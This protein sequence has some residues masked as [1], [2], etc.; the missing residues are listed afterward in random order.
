MPRQ[1]APVQINQ[2][3]GGLNTEA[4]I[5]NFPENFSSDEQNMEICEDGSRKQ[6][7]GFNFEDS[8]I[9][10]DTTI[11][12]QNGESLGRS[13]YR[14]I[15]PGGDT[16][17][18]FLVVQIGNYMAVHDLDVSPLS[19]S[20]IYYKTF[21]DNTYSEVF[22]YAVVDGVLV[23][24][25]GK[26]AV[27]IFT[28]DADTDSITWTTDFL[29]IRD[30]FGT[31]AHPGGQNTTQHQNIQI[32]PTATGSRHIYNLR[33]QTFAL[34]RV[35]GDANTLTKV[36]P[37]H[38][39][40]LASGSEY[41]PSNADN[42]TYYLLADANLTTSRTVER[43]NAND[44]VN[45]PPGTSRAPM[46]Y[47]IIDALKR[48]SS[49][50]EQA[51]LLY[52]RNEELE[53]PI[54]N[55]LELDETPGGA[56]VL[57]QY[58]GRIWYGGF[59]SDI[60]DPHENSPRLSSYVLFSR[61]ITDITQITNCYQEA[62]PTSN[63][64][65]DLG[66]DDGG[67][68]K[69]DGA[70]GIK[71]MIPF[72]SSLFVFA[73]N[74]VWRIAGSDGDS[75]RATSPSVFKLSDYGII[76]PNSLIEREGKIF[77]WGEEG[78]FVVSQNQ[79]GDWEVGD[80]TVETI[81][82]LYEDIAIG[83]KARSVGYFDMS[84]N[85]IRW[86][87]GTGL[88]NPT[89]S[90]E[91]ILNLRFNSFTLNKIESNDLVTGVISVSGGRKISASTDPVVVDSDGEVV[92][93]DGEDV[94]SA[95]YKVN[96]DPAENLYCV[97]IEIEPTLT[98][99]FGGYKEG[100]LYDWEDLTAT[101]IDAYLISGPLTGGD[102]RIRKDIPYL[103]T[104]FKK[105]DDSGCLVNAIWD[106]ASGVTS[107]KWTNPRQAYRLRRENDGDFMVVTRNRVRGNGRSVSFKFQSEA[108]KTMRLY[109]WEFNLEA[110]DKE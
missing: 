8:Y 30:L 58:A 13:Q 17:K 67:F 82:T 12:Q 52:E 6:R 66:D 44:M 43:F 71:A 68:L 83:Q 41:Y 59:S 80:I 62:D 84:S 64:D 37:I 56:S 42:L 38:E 85:S 15:N 93:S 73:E 27:N 9:E 18:E 74:G 98:Y 55:T 99:S 7:E 78:I 110:G 4:N 29:R 90:Y 25:T 76:S 105:Q 53:Y 69:L 81:K 101:E 10:V 88:N 94:T 77:Y 24:V 54:T 22:N 31:E 79:F 2:F 11:I 35:E 36:D 104:Y 109:G 65:A 19:N 63:I 106:W 40:F 72:Q 20:R 92:T 89:D 50:Y 47:F 97:L 60:I 49:R 95:S 100:T 51:Q 16:N 48:G 96:R 102:G 28:Y 32:R 61:V 75:F 57:S 107:G 45:T 87:Y 23:V 3:V 103:T 14:W 108:G 91:L 86:V 1:R 26:R 46:G 39:F 70:Y 21:T 33:N 34:P 5:I